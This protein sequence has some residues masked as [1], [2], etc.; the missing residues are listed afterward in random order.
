MLEAFRHGRV[1]N[2]TMRSVA[3]LDIM[4]ASRLLATLRDRDLLVLHPAGASSYFELPPHLQPGG[5]PVNSGPSSR[6]SG[7]E[8][9]S[10]GGT[11]VNSAEGRFRGEGARA[12]ILSFCKGRWLTPAEVATHLQT[13]SVENLTRRHLSPMVAE[14]L[15]ERRH[16]EKN[17]P[18]QA[19]RTVET[20][21]G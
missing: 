18:Q 3:G 12:A 17:H 10:K 15:L 5:T 16:E 8:L 7:G 6:Q 9:P 11:P 20:E 2:A 13:R 1:T 21:T 19:Y 4:R 14:G